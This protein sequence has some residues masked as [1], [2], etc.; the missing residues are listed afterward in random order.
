VETP[1]P[2]VVFKSLTLKTFHGRWSFRAWEQSEKLL[3]ENLSVELL[4]CK[5]QSHKSMHAYPTIAKIMVVLA[6]SGRWV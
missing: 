6:F 1:L 3:S 4:R 2:D 5:S